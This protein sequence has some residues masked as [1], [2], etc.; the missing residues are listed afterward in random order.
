MLAAELVVSAVLALVGAIYL[1][2]DRLLKSKAA[3]APYDPAS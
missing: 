2:P 1:R 3:P